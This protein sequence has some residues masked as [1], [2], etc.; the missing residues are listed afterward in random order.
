MSKDDDKKKKIKKTLVL[1]RAVELRRS[2]QLEA[3]LQ[4]DRGFSTS[5][6]CIEKV[7]ELEKIIPIDPMLLKDKKPEGY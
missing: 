4:W 6:E 3:L 1:N 7:V 5:R 2:M